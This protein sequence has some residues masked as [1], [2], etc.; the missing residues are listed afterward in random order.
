MLRVALA[1]VLV[2]VPWSALGQ[3]APTSG[4]TDLQQR[5]RQRKIIVQ[6]KPSPEAIARDAD[7]AVDEL[8]A[9]QRQEQTLRELNRPGSPRP[10]LDQ[11]VTGGIQT[12]NLNRP[13]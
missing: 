13:R 2:L 3:S 1:I 11:N 5:M 7:Q 6:P 4:D 10:D 9:R 8:A 12:R